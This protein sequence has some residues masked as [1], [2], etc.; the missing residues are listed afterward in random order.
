M[1]I[2][3]TTIE[4]GLHDDGWWRSLIDSDVDL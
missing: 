4:V 1:E 2:Y 3:V